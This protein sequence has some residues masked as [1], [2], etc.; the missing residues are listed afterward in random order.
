YILHSLH[1]LPDFIL[2]LLY[3]LP[4]RVNYAIISGGWKALLYIE[5]KV[6]TNSLSYPKDKG[7]QNTGFYDALLPYELLVSPKVRG[8][9]CRYRKRNSIT[10]PDIHALC[11]MLSRHVLRA[12]G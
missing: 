6:D 4:V 7:I 9:I 10:R 5:I 3:I 2:P 12:G 8:S 1:F 11:C